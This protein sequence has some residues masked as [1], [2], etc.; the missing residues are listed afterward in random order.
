MV[1][2]LSRS[3]SVSDVY[4][5]HGNRSGARSASRLSSVSDVSSWEHLD[6]THPP[7]TAQ[8]G[9]ERSGAME[10][11]KQFPS[12][13][14]YRDTP[15]P[16]SPM[17]P[18]VPV[19]RFSSHSADTGSLYTSPQAGVEQSALSSNQACS[20]SSLLSHQWPGHVGPGQSALA[21]PVGH[22]AG[23]SVG[24]VGHPVGSTVGHTAGA[25]VGPV[26]HA[27][28]ANR[29]RVPAILPLSSAQ[30]SVQPSS[31]QN[32]PHPSPAPG[33]HPSITPVQHTW[34]DSYDSSKPHPNHTSQPFSHRL[35]S[36]LPHTH[37]P[38]PLRPSSTGQSYSVADPSCVHVQLEPEY[39]AP[40][41][42]TAAVAA[43]EYPRQQVV[44]SHSPI[45]HSHSSVTHSHSSIPSLQSES[46]HPGLYSYSSAYPTSVN[47]PVAP[48]NLHVSLSRDQFPSG[49]MPGIKVSWSSS[50][51]PP[52]SA[53]P[54][55]PGDTTVGHMQRLGHSRH[56]SLG[57][58][59]GAGVGRQKRPTHAR[60]RSLGSI[61]PSSSQALPL[62]TLH[63][64]QGSCSNLSM[65]S[66]AS[67]CGSELSAG[68]NFLTPS[69]LCKLPDPD[70]GYD[71]AQHFNL[72]S[73]YTSN[74]ALELCVSE[75]GSEE[76]LPTVPPVWCMAFWNRVVAV[77]C[78][79]G[80][81]EV[82]EGT[83]LSN[84]IFFVIGLE[85]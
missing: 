23:T 28:G 46:S 44:Q 85:C 65:M 47:V 81:V 43:T 2:H 25:S 40:A 63:S 8:G 13:H 42:V 35:Q 67:I 30:S 56:L 19:R 16:P 3:S 74:M 69:Q 12:S 58:Q 61:P 62:S 68:S 15:T 84:D 36:S 53:T 20:P 1:S 48:S 51:T 18:S 22:I 31:L 71:F 59:N 45:V 34:S 78:S 83:V 6:H 76:R 50:A 4:D 29:G 5:H 38:H 80:Q 77:G 52:L 49:S 10:D 70:K 17:L 24:P 9:T 37:L 79:N 21:C 73:Q 11:S 27:V 14:A 55:L 41:A 60:N 32:R 26:G 54:L 64:T 7:N 39:S 66:N 75:R 82:R 72:F 57:G 33:P